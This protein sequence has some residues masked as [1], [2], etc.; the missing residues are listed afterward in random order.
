MKLALPMRADRCRTRLSQYSTHS[1]LCRSYV[2]SNLRALLNASPVAAMH[3]L[4]RSLK[5]AILATT[6]LLA[7]ATFVQAA[8][9][10][11]TCELCCSSDSDSCQRAFKGGKAHCCGVNNSGRAFCCPSSAS[12]VQRRVSKGP[13]FWEDEKIWKCQEAPRPPTLAGEIGP[14]ALL[15][16]SRLLHSPLPVLSL[17]LGSS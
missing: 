2:P 4:S 17:S 1:T 12:C 15:R 8:E 11:T 7:L 6:L 10:A 14:C 3:H 9:A 13:P 5:R 16:F